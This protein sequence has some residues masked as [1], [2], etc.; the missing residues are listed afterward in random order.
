[1]KPPRGRNN[2]SLP[3]DWNFTDID[4]SVTAD[5]LS[6]GDMVEPLEPM[7]VQEGTFAERYRGE[8]GEKHSIASVVGGQLA[9]AYYDTE[10]KPTVDGHTWGLYIGQRRIRSSRK[11]THNPKSWF[12]T[13]K[14]KNIYEVVH[15]FDFGGNR[16]IIDPENVR[17]VQ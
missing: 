11:L 9:A 13:K 6:P 8:S 16:I 3:V 2:R 15:I 12:G 1:M 7:T 17:R 5:K 10:G 14:M 4:D